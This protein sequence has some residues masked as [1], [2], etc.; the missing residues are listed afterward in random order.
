ML[1]IKVQ[2]QRLNITQ[3]KYISLLKFKVNTILAESMVRPFVLQVI[4]DVKSN[5][6]KASNVDLSLHNETNKPV[7]YSNSIF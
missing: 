7:H 4:P 1:R 2:I 5:F 6:L 3:I